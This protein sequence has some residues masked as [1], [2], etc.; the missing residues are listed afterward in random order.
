M[1]N[2]Y[3]LYSHSTL[4][5][6]IYYIGIGKKIYTNYPYARAYNKNLRTKFWKNVYNK[7]G[8]VVNILLESDD[9][10]FIIE[11]EIELINLHGRRD[12]KTGNL[13]N[14]TAGGEG[15]NGR[16][17]DIT[18]QVALKNKGKKRTQEVKEKFRQIKLNQSVETRKKISE[19]H[20][21]KEQPWSYKPVLQFDKKGVFI[22]KWESISH[23]C[24]ILGIQ[25]TY[26]S[27]CCNK[28]KSRKT[29]G[30]FKWEFFNEQTKEKYGIE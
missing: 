15:T 26:I 20:M 29:A 17:P 21:G 28:H 27:R 24:K 3:Y 18:K 9:R 8:L 30:G 16:S 10:N 7:H 25:Q 2:I 23:A 5:G 13:V 4:S 22:Q 12:L 19:S 14:L 6:E 1:I 11:K